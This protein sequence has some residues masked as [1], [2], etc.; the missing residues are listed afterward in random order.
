M[1]SL[2]RLPVAGCR[3]STPLILRVWPLRGSA[4]SDLLFLRRSNYYYQTYKLYSCATALHRWGSAVGKSK[5]FL[6]TFGFSCLHWFP[7]LWVLGFDA[8]DR[9]DRDGSGSGTWCRCNAYELGLC[10]YTC[11]ML[12]YGRKRT[13]VVMHLR[14]ILMWSGRPDLRSIATIKIT[15]FN[16]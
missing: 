4:T 5:D 12:F 8:L 1:I 3:F 9:D 16:R 2:G 11:T 7:A 6:T 13:S 15:T 10:A 14:I